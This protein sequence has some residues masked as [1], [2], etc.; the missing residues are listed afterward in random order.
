MKQGG[1]AVQQIVCFSGGHS[2]ALA[3]IETVRQYGKENV[4]LLNH[5]I[6]NKA[7]HEDIKQF[8]QDVA[9]YLDL[10]ITP[11]NSTKYP[12]CTPLEVCREIRCFTNPTT[13]QAL[14]TYELKTVPFQNWLKANHPTVRGKVNTDCKII[15]GF[16][17][18]EQH[19]I[20]RRVGVMGAQGYLTDYPLACWKRTID[21]TEDIGIP[22]PRTYRI[23]KHANCFPCLKAGRQHWYIAYCL[24]RDLF[25]EAMEIEQDI[26]Y[27]IIKGTFLEEFIPKFKEMQAN[28]ICPN[29]REQS[30]SFWARVENACPEQMTFL[31]C[32]CAVL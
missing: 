31:P 13:Q 11:A 28:G 20:Q 32:D 18:T 12:E 25:D 21:C 26:G 3:A 22:R 10:P 7:E 2:S 6:S 15:Y 19:R 14:C 23:F 30:Q 27:S 17:M 1:V 29:D 4:I 8:K 5:D 16:D 9:D 24:R